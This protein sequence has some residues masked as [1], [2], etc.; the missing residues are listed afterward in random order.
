MPASEN[1][2]KSGSCHG[3]SSQPRFD[4][5][6]TSEPRFRKQALPIASRSELCHLVG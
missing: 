3:E 5:D 6:F 2:H 1:L 4:Y